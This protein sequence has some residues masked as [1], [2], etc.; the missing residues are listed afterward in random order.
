MNQRHSYPIGLPLDGRVD[1]FE[2]AAH[3]VRRADGDQLNAVFILDDLHFL[4]GLNTQRRAHRAGSRLDISV[5]PG[6]PPCYL[7]IDILFV[8]RGVIL[9][10]FI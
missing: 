10:Y 9:A 7:R 8:I 5:K 3:L 4:A 6:P 1:A 2:E